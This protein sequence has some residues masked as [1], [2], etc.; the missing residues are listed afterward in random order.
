MKLGLGKGNRC[1]VLIGKGLPCG[2]C[3][4]NSFCLAHVKGIL[5][6]DVLERFQ[7]AHGVQTGDRV[8][9]D[10]RRDDGNQP[11]GQAGRQGVG[12]FADVY[13]EPDVG[14]CLEVAPGC[15]VGGK[16]QGGEPDGVH[17]GREGATTIK[18]LWGLKQ[19]TFGF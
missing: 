17:I 14:R 12:V 9:G 1:C 11:T 8:A 13:A 10:A 7:Q 5:F 19:R 6:G 3:T 16:V 2:A 18:A 15:R 4:C